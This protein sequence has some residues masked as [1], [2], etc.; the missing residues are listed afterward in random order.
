MGV[1]SFSCGNKSQKKVDLNK[2]LDN[3]IERVEDEAD[4]LDKTWD[5]T[6]KRP[7]RKQRKS[8]MK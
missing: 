2:A 5:D 8:N 1:A 4:K 7:G 3:A 6:K